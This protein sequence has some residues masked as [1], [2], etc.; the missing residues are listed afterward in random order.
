[1]TDNITS[2]QLNNSGAEL[3]AIHLNKP[4]AAVEAVAVAGEELFVN[5]LINYLYRVPWPYL[6]L[7]ASQIHRK[8][9]QSRTR[10]DHRAA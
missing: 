7:P 5:S 6:T 9:S 4:A 8:N 3:R 10:H 2:H 1:M